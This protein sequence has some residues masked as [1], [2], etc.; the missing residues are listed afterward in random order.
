MYYESTTIL[1]SPVTGGVTHS[2]G[3]QAGNIYP[4]Y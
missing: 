4:V 1:V 3:G 2:Y